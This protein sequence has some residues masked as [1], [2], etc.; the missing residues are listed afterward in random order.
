MSHVVVHNVF[1]SH[2]LRGYCSCVSGKGTLINNSQPTGRTSTIDAAHQSF[3]RDCQTEY[4]QCPT[5]PA[6]SERLPT[7]PYVHHKQFCRVIR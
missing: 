7:E 2:T 5:Q 1:R 6:V 4:R 3:H